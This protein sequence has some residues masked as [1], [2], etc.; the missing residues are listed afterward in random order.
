[1]FRGAFLILFI[2]SF[3]AGG[4]KAGNY[5]KS[6]ALKKMPA[7]V[8]QIFEDALA[9]F[10]M[11]RALIGSQGS[12]VL[13]LNMLFSDKFLVSRIGVKYGV[14]GSFKKNRSYHFDNVNVYHF[15]LAGKTAALF[16]QNIDEKDVRKMVLALKETAAAQRESSFSLVPEAR[17][18]EC[19]K[20]SIGPELAVDKDVGEAAA[21]AM[22]T[23]CFAGMGDGAKSSTVGLAED[24]W[25]ALKS[26][27]GAFAQEARRFYEAPRARLGAYSRFVGEGMQMLASFSMALGKM[28]L[29][30]AEGARVLKEKFG[31]IGSFFGDAYK[32]LKGMPFAAKVDVICNIVGAIGADVLIAAVTV[33]A[34]SGKLGVTIARLLSKLKKTAVLIGK[35]VAYPFGVLQKLSGSTLKKLEKIV[36]DGNKDML[37]RKLKRKGCDF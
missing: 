36:A 29:D 13:G 24:V 12:R 32:S 28:M 5:Y 17:A 19:F 26:A 4:A 10:H 31:A 7:S 20:P 3:F 30:P 1:M 2:T 14:E 27:G 16:Y 25:S 15:D 21:G 9:R 37:D 11:R 22:L 6:P 8:E 18:S 34:A 35:G 33:G 23:K